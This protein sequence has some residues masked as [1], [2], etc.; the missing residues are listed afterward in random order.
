[1]STLAGARAMITDDLRAE[2]AQA[3]RT[4][5][6]RN[7]PAFALA[8]AG[9][10]LVLTL[11]SLALAWRSRAAAA[12]VLE[13]E[14]GRLTRVGDLA[15]QFEAVERRLAEGGAEIASPM[16]DVFSR[17]EEAATEAGLR[18]KPPISSPQS[19]VVGGAVKQTYRYET[20]R[21][22]SLGALL[23]WVERCQARI[24]GLRVSSV[25]ITPEAKDWRMSVSFVRWERQP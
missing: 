7:R 17:I 24:P 15:V 21:D 10:L 2:L 3:A 5:E 1:M 16:R 8:L 14:H 9:V 19:Q 18:D 6:G 4:A 23:A 11:V 22:P 25:E 13:I 12:G 20:M